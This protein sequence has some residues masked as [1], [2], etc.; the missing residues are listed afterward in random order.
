MKIIKP[1]FQIESEINPH[2]IYE[3]LENIARTC[4]KSE[5][6]GDMGDAAGF[7]RRLIDRGHE[8]MIEHEHITVRFI[9]NRGFTHELVRHRIA[10]YA[11]E[12]T[13]YCNYSKDK[14]GNELTFIEPY[15]Y[16]EEEKTSN[17]NDGAWDVLM[18]Q[19]EEIYLTMIKS[20]PAQAAR[21]ILPND[22]KTEIVIT[23]N[24]REWRAIFKLRCADAAHPD[25]R[26]V[27]IPLQN[28]LKNLL[29]DIFF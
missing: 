21:G 9:H 28:E 29:P 17:L 24:L 13:R 12:S 1:S 15:W 6:V 25:M 26:R 8:A 3:N 2:K 19:I 11:Q 14:F 23:A 4:Y 7:I 5:S 16:K 22:I 10:S 27:M 18:E 20:L